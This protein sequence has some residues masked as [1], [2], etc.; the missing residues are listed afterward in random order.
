M[1]RYNVG[2]VGCGNISG[3]Y[4]KNMT[5]LFARQL[6]VVACTDID[7]TAAE[8]MAAEFPGVKAVSYDEMLADP[9]IDIVVNL[10]VPKAHFDVALAAVNAGKHV[11]G[12]KP[13]TLALDESRTLLEAARKK[14]VRISNAPDTFLGA[15]HQTCRK[16]IDDGAIG[17]P[18][19]ATA[20]ML[21]R[22]H[23]TWHPNPEFHY[24]PGGGPM[25]DM[26]P[27]YLTALVNML[28]P[29]SR[30]SGS[31]RI[32]FP[33]RTITSEK[34]YGQKIQVEVPTHVTGVLDF[35]AGAIATI[36]T[37]FDVYAHRLPFIEIHG[38]AGSLAVPDPNHFGG[39]VQIWTPEQ[40]EWTTVAHTH[41][42][43]ENSRGIGVADMAAAIDAGTDHS[44]SG[45][46]ACHVLEIMH[47]IHTAS[48]RGRHIMLQSSCGR[49]PVQPQKSR[50][51]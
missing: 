11:Y 2:I 48:T 10:T 39:E 35:A 12:E 5:T 50:W 7:P 30:V 23:E 19:S 3:I 14:S 41:P 6:N 38:S 21:C 27:Y 32:N 20:F 37:S 43:S 36:T 40:P 13:M 24:Q 34:K 16:L 26:G 8:A 51:E 17:K 28:G 29:V 46:L 31:T 1:K 15:A 44:A 42:Y 49:P 33:V 25:F 45:Q 4:F 47:T 18:V 22:G 9:A